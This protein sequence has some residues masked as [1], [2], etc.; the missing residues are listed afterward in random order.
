VVV[1]LANMGPGRR[2]Q[3]ASTRARSRTRAGSVS[4]RG[5]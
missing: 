4:E 2:E 1:V 3:G 5:L